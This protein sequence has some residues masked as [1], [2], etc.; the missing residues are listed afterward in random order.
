M[1]WDTVRVRLLGPVDV[2]VDGV[3][4]PLSG[5]RRKTVLAV[6]G[7]R[8]DE[9]VSTD[10]LIDIVWGEHP[11]AT[12]AN[13][14]QSHVSYLRGVLGSRSA[15]VARPPGYLLD[16]P[17]E[18]TDVTLATDLIRQ[19]EQESDHEQSAAHLR[20]ALALWR[21]RALADVA[22]VPWLGEQGERLEDIRLDAVQALIDVRMA[23]GE[24]A[25]LIPELERMAEQ[26]PF[27][28]HIHEQLMLALYRSGRQ[29]DALGAYQRLRQTI[30]A[31]LGI[32]PSPALRDLEVAILR[33]DDALDAPAARVIGALPVATTAPTWAVPA[34]LPLAVPTFTGR[35]V[36]L[37]RLDA[38]L[39]GADR[40]RPTEP[41]A[42]TISVVSGTAGVGKTA[43]A[44]HWAHQVASQFPDGQLYV[45]LRGFDP[46][47]TILEPA[48]AIRGFLDAFAVP[49]A[50][51]PDA[52]DSQASLYRSVLAT[53]RVLIV[54]DNARDDE[55]V[56]PL[57]PGAPGCLVVVTSRSQLGG[58]IA[59]EDA[60]PINLDLPTDADAREMLT[61][62]LGRRRVTEEPDAV[63]DIIARCARLPLA[64]AVAAA[65]AATNRELPLAKLA[66]ELHDTAA[67]LDSFQSGDSLTDVRA[68]FSWSYRTLSS[69]AARLFRLLG[70]CSGPDIALAAAASLIGLPPRRVRPLLAE[71]TRVHL[72]T[73]PTPGRFGF[74]DLLRAYAIEQARLHDT[75]ATR[76]EAVHRVLD[77]Y[78]HTGHAAALLLSP[79]REPLAVAAPQ[80]GVMP[81]PLIDRSAAAAWFVAEHPVLLATVAAES[82]GFERHR[83]Q[84]A[85]TLTSFL[86]R[87]GYW[88]DFLA[89]QTAGLE[90]A[91]RIADSRGQA[92]MHRNLGTVHVKLGNF[93]AADRHDR[94]A[95]RL[96]EVVGDRIAQVHVHLS[97]AWVAEQQGNFAEALGHAQFAIPQYEMAG[98]RV[99]EAHAL[100]IL[101]WCHAKLGEYEPALG[102]CRRAIA[103]FDELGDRTGA[104]GT[105]DSLGFIHFQLG[106]HD[107]GADCF[108]EAVQIYRELGDRF[109]EA[110]AYTSLGD[111]QRDIG[112]LDAARD[113]WREALAI[114]EELGHPVAG[115]V[116]ARLE[117]A[118][119][120]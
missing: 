49:A 53:K 61:R 103:V 99:G 112:N 110:D 50:R 21:G 87:R 101:G 73:E 90:A 41:Q 22:G 68:V 88:R 69:D 36:E 44:I 42:V 105:W 109:N 23:M 82:A 34:Q 43:L 65:R 63:R 74:H 58:L 4:Q 46:G 14:L 86:D 95:L 111:A 62:R 51:I 25:Q 20:A 77:H 39:S 80:P 79:Q 15:I 35:A 70:L 2:V 1:S 117:V 76:S 98:N 66:L 89:V 102:Y 72:V 64:L 3:T 13:T 67:A 57:L 59:T 33:Q 12:A 92:H 56:R 94:Q 8:A 32:D 29:A 104:A 48:E 26:H 7:L 28:E 40:D 118:P 19:S 54:L 75:E 47:G 116:R 115:D 37:G 119:A 113:A 27:R 6:L 9:T 85:W 114:L 81:E 45:N 107:R 30:S 106:E 100:N 31:E 78:L 5:L 55:Q 16:L 52:P 91:I 10:R 83:W 93:E 120:R 96:F 108:D 84:L 38:M 71:L 24:H 60:Q 18:A 17:A 97:L 11:P